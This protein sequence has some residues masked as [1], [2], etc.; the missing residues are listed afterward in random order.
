V[1]RKETNLTSRGLVVKKKDGVSP[2]GP[3]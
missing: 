2:R 1:L 3:A